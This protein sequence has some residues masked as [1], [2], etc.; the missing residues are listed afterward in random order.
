MRSSSPF[1]LHVTYYTAEDA[2]QGLRSP[3]ERGQRDE[4]ESEITLCCKR[5]KTQQIVWLAVRDD[6]RNWMVTAVQ[7]RNAP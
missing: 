7:L 1:R 5:L 3:S 4:F 6:F 2:A